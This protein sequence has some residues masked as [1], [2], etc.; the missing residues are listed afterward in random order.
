VSAPSAAIERLPGNRLDDVVDVFADA[1]AG[2]PVMRH[3]VGPNGDVAARERRLVRLFVTRRVARGG[4]MYGVWRAGAGC[5]VLGAILLTYPNEPETPEVARISAEAWAEL[6][7]DARV[8]YDEYARASNFFAAY[9]PHLHLNMIGVRRSRKGTGLGRRLLEKTRELAEA[10]L[11][12]AGVS[13]TTEIPRNV[14]LYRHF[15]YEVVGQA[16]FGPGITTWGMYL[17]I[18]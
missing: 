6:G 8:R 15:G 10:D 9:P 5:A 2:Y 13:L 16:A 1:F 12:L 11:R 7:D 4:P 18:R 17:R 3:T 14:E